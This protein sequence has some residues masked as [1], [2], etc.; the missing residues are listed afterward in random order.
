MGVEYLANPKDAAMFAAKDPQMFAMITG[1]LTT[2]T[3]PAMHAKLNMHVGAIDNLQTQRQDQAQQ[4]TN[5]IN[6]LA[7]R[8][9]LARD[10]WWPTLQESDPH[11]ARWLS[12]YAFTTGKPP[13]YLGSYDDFRVFQGIFKNK[14]TSRKAKGYLVVRAG[15]VSAGLPEYIEVHGDIEILKAFIAVAEKRHERLSRVW[16]DTLYEKGR[17][18]KQNLIAAAENLEATA[19]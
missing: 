9:D 8:I 2:A 7:G 11:G 10:N 12:S 3:T 18:N 19:Q 6:A 4:Y 13:Q 1:Y 5:A 16:Y 15:S 17:N 14:N